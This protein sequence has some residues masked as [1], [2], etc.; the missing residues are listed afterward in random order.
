[1]ET[2]AQHDFLMREGCHGFQGY[3]ISRPMPP[4]LFEAM[5]EQHLAS[6]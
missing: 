3:L 2:V 5:L 4:V 6:V 1:V